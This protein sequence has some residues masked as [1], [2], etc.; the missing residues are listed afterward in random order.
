MI[1]LNFKLEL[2]M[3]NQLELRARVMRGSSSRLQ[4]IRVC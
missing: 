3:K 4:E 2:R 1:K